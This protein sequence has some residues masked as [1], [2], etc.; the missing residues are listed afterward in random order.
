MGKHYTVPG[1]ESDDA[2]DDTTDDYDI[3]DD[4]DKGERPLK[5]LRRDS[6]QPRN[7]HKRDGHH[8]RPSRRDQDREK[9]GDHQR[10]DARDKDR[11][12]D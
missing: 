9:N 11:D 12:D 6:D 10:D 5:K 2:D 3:Q 7:R 8:H 1:S 4:L